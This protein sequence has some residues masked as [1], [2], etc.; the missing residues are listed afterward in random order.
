MPRLRL[1]FAFALTSVACTEHAPP[2]ESLDLA[3]ATPSLSP[4]PHLPEAANPRVS[5]WLELRRTPVDPDVP[6]CGFEVIAHGFPAVHADGTAI[7]HAATHLDGNADRD[8]E[9]MHLTTTNVDDPTA[10]ET[11]VVY[12]R[13]HHINRPCRTVLRDVASQLRHLNT[14]LA[15][16]HWH[17]LD[18]LAVTIVDRGEYADIREEHPFHK[19]HPIEFLYQRGALVA[20]TNNR[21]LEHHP[22]ADLKGKDEFCDTTPHLTTLFADPTS[23]ATLVFY[24]HS[25]GGCLCD[26]HEF[27]TTLRLGPELFATIAAS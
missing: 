8:A 19:N 11:E 25:N 22:R 7:V 15:R 2:V 14:E 10:V 20:R 6:V 5:P 3:E 9:Y 21:I 4:V 13:N 1:A 27:H 24:N 17:T 18:R 12:D 16:E 26:D 23:G